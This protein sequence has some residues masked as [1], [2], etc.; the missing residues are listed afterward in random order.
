[1][2]DDVPISNEAMFTF[3]NHD[4]FEDIDDDPDFDLDA[5]LE[6]IDLDA[7]R[8]SKRN[9]IKKKVK[10]SEVVQSGEYRSADHAELIESMDTDEL[11]EKCKQAMMSIADEEWENETNV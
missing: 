8:P 7:P 4:P 3:I 5:G 11:H 1:M 10:W 6:D 2:T 9:V